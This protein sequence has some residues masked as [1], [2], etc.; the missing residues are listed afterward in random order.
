MGISIVL[1][2]LFLLVLLAVA[3][4]AARLLGGRG[5]DGKR[6]VAGCL[7]GCAVGLGLF[8]LGSLGLAAL[9]AALTVQSAAVVVGHNPVRRIYLGTR[10]A[11]EAAPDGQ[12]PWVGFARDPERPLH[13][14]FEIEGHGATPGNLLHWIREWSEGEATVDSRDAFDAQG[15]P[16][17]RIDVALPARDRELREIERE[18]RKFVPGADWDDGLQIEFKGASREG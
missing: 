8:L 15:R 3:F 6:D 5:P 11:E 14:V 10:S 12:A 18:V 1:F 2:A 7:T 9:I 4:A 17:T 16:V 13:L